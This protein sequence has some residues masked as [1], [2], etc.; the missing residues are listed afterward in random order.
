[1]HSDIIILKFIKANMNNICSSKN[2]VEKIIPFCSKDSGYNGWGTGKKMLNVQ[3][4][5]SH[6]KTKWICTK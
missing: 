2:F 4:Y 1:M 5:I 3:K 6:K